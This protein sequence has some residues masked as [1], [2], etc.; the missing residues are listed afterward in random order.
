MAK[1]TEGHGVG[2]PDLAVGPGPEASD[3]HRSGRLTAII[4]GVVLLAHL[5]LPWWR[6]LGGRLLF[7]WTAEGYKGHAVLAATGVVGAMVALLL[8]RGSAGWLLAGVGGGLFLATQGLNYTPFGTLREH[9]SWDSAAIGGLLLAGLAAGLRA[10]RMGRPVAGDRLARLSAW[11]ILCAVGIVVLRMLDQRL[12][13]IRLIEPHRIAKDV[14]PLWLWHGLFAAGWIALAVAWLTALLA[15]PSER[16]TRIAVRVGEAAAKAV[17]LLGVTA[18]AI[19]AARRHL[20]GPDLD[21][22]AGGGRDVWS[23]VWFAR[24]VVVASAFWFLLADGLAEV[25]GGSRSVPP[26]EREAHRPRR[27]AALIVDALLLIGMGI[28]V[29]VARH[30]PVFHSVGFA[31]VGLLGAVGLAARQRTVLW[32][33]VVLAAASYLVFGL[34]SFGAIRALEVFPNGPGPLVVAFLTALTVA[35]LRAARLQG[36]G[37]LVA[38]LG[39][40]AAMVLIVLVA[41]ALV[42]WGFA[43]PESRQSRIESLVSDSALWVGHTPR[44]LLTVVGAVAVGV[45]LVM[46]AMARSRRRAIRVPCCVIGEIA[47]KLAL[48][49]S[50]AFLAAVAVQEQLAGPTW[51]PPTTP[52]RCVLELGSVIWLVMFADGVSTIPYAAMP[53]GAQQAGRCVAEQAGASDRAPPRR[54]SGEA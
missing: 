51:P 52:L 2:S 33:A 23:N 30:G 48:L 54:S 32:V 15:L 36:P 19:A 14:L 43:S 5:V 4:V 49:G 45:A 41:M 3:A 44:G 28:A 29:W 20:A 27:G 31:G 38:R 42:G 18:V 7:S 6:S 37:C 10:R 47:G 9:M 34:T 24:L 11:M 39:A 40:T 13:L 25:A 53:K 26:R 22:W 35:G 16:Q 12:P 8:R 46:T 21:V 50:A 17:V 1:R